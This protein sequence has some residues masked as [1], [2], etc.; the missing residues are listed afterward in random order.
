MGIVIATSNI[1]NQTTEN[2][3][4]ETQNQE[5]PQTEETNNEENSSIGSDNM[6]N[7]QNE[8]IK[9]NLIVNNKTYSATLENNETTRELTTMFP[10]T[11]NMSEMNSNEKYNYLDTALTTN[12][13]RPNRINAGDIKLYGNDCL[14][15]FYKSFNT[16]YSYTDLGRVDN[17]NDFVSE[18]G[19]GS[20]TITFELAE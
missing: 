17:V 10:M 9:I 6:M 11:L 12:S 7:N 3:I 20:V 5:S 15:V 19:S 16:V 4:D 13:S 14:V 18:L 1:E 2:T 8:E